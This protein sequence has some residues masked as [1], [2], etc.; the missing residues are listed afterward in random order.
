[1]DNDLVRAEKLLSENNVRLSN[2][3]NGNQPFDEKEAK[4]FYRD[5]YR[6]YFAY[7]DSRSDNM[8]LIG[9]LHCCRRIK[10]C[11]PGWQ[12]KIDMVLSEGN[13]TLHGTYLVDLSKHTISIGSKPE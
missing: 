13:C 10:Y 1:M 9:L 8:I 11:Y 2:K 5:W 7:T 3:L 6:Q 4:D 12:N